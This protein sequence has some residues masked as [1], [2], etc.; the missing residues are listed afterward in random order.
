MKINK[1]FFSLLLIAG[2][3]SS[4]T[5]DWLETTKEGTPNEGNFWKNDADYIKAVT[6]LY[7]CY[8]YEETWGRDLFYEQG[9]GDDIVYGRNRGNSQMNLAKL[10]MDGSSEGSIKW[11]YKQ[12]YETMSAA[13]NIIYH[14]LLIP[15]NERT[16]VQKRSLGEAYFMRAFTHFM[17]A[18]RYGRP[19]NGV[20]FVKYEDFSNY[21]RQ[22]NEV[23]QQQNTVMDNYRLIV[24]DLQKAA[25]CLDW[26][27]NY[28]ADN[29]GRATRDAALGFMVKT[30]AYWAQHDNS[31]WAKIPALV[32]KIENE[33]GRGLL[34]SYADVFKAE[35]EWSKEYI[36]SINSRGSNYAGSIFPGISLENKGWGVFNGWGY[37]KP[38]LELYAEY[39]DQ[40]QRRDATLLAYGDSFK[41]FGENWKWYSNSDI[42]V[43]FAFKKYMEPFSYGKIIRDGNGK[44]TGYENSHISTN[45]DRP[46]TD[47]NVPLMR[48]SELLLFKAEALIMQGQNNAAAVVLNRIAN[49]AQEGVTYTAP[50]MIELMHERRCELAFEWTDRLM[51]LKRWAAGG[52]AAWNL[53][54][55]AKIR[56]AKHGIK[57]VDRT[58]PDSP[59]DMTNGTTLTINGKTYH[60]V[61]TIG[62]GQGDAKDYE[63]GGTYSVLPYEINQ[64]IKSNGKLKQNKG[65]ASNF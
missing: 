52:N 42:E 16:A 38:T 15:E 3:L 32:D 9:A 46:T 48:F 20:P 36:W 25:D 41:Y 57:H 7:D 53:D 58:N 26:F 5:G 21:E 27:K 33:G 49:R 24:E 6:T 35:N 28:T 34:N 1:I 17:I 60:G 64:V 54:A 40:D 23:P 43:G 8:A 4:C 63:P 45:G 10:K 55:L 13:N 22:I 39:N 47:L 14:A 59:V 12:M 11:F 61:I 62:A 30:Y 65:Y 18:Y 29:Y 37:M 31:Q 50:T 2:T 19:D 44:I 56:G 51:D